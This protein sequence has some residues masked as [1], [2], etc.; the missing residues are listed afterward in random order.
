M[1]ISLFVGC[2][3]CLPV[4]RI[5]LLKDRISSY[6]SFVLCSTWQVTRVTIGAEQML[7]SFLNANAS[8]YSCTKLPRSSQRSTTEHTGC[9]HRISR[10]DLG[11]KP[12][13][14]L[15]GVGMERFS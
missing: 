14:V 15:K 4:G 10:S 5:Y 1:I 6:F 2:S 9:M 7:F 12:C 3:F 11:S 13:S 8:G